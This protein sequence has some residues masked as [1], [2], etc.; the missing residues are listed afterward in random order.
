MVR[1][2]LRPAA[3]AAA[4]LLSPILAQ[5]RVVAIGIAKSNNHVYAWHDD[6]M[7]TAGSPT[8]FELH[9]KADAYGLGYPAGGYRP[10]GE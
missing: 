8:D 10:P 2:M 3:V 5:A 7:V 1:F 9:R 4:L 6:R